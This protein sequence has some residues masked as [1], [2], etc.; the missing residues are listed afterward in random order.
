MW[1]RGTLA[2]TVFGL[3]S[4]S[5][6]AQ[7]AAPVTLPLKPPPAK[8]AE[9]APP[10]KPLESPVPAPQDVLDAPVAEPERVEPPAP[11][12]QTPPLPQ[13]K[14][15]FAESKTA[16]VVSEPD[17]AEMAP[18]DDMPGGPPIPTPPGGAPTARC[19]VRDVMA[20]YDRT[21]VRCYNKVRGKVV[22]F[23]VDTS[24]PVAG[25]VLSKALK[26][27][28]SGKPV[29]ITYAPGTDLNPSNCG[30]KDCRRLLDIQN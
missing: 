21:H 4:W 18:V 22:F 23:A 6:V 9:A 3:L 28:Q 17:G 20:F 30:R 8:Q 29:T 5:A 25:T 26:G 12:L 13:P 10:T 11:A 24:Q 14:P 19:F 1:R 2:L 15:H 7:D 16:A 27:M